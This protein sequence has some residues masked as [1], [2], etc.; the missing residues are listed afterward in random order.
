MLQA[1]REVIQPAEH[2]LH[3]GDN[4]FLYFFFTLYV[5]EFPIKL[6]CPFD[7]LTNSFKSYKGGIPPAG[8]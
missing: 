6:E 4:L 8:M 1:G 3:S 2:R 7:N 5:E